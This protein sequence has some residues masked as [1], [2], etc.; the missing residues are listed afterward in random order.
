M[1]EIW[2]DNY[3]ISEI[4][5][6]FYC[7][8]MNGTPCMSFTQPRGLNIKEMREHLL[9]YIN[10]KTMIDVNTKAGDSDE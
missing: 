1:K 4:E 10:R 6:S 5:P 3:S 2:I 7:I 9:E 8:S